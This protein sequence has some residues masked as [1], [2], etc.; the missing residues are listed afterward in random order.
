MTEKTATPAEKVDGPLL[1][2]AF[3]LVLGTFMASID[4]TIVSV[5]IDTLADEFHAS[6]AEIQWVSTAYLLAVV[7]AVP[8]SGW[9]AD[10]LGGRRVWLVAVGVFLCGS[11]LCALSW[12][13]TS[14]IV[15]RVLQGLGAG[16]LP[17]TGQALLARIAGPARTG[18]VISVVAVVPLLS[19]VLGPLAA[20]PC[21]GRPPGHGCSWS[22]CRSASPRS[23]SPAAMC[24]CWN[25]RP[26]GPR[27]MCGGP[28]C[29]HPASP[30]WCSA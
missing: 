20:A 6:L 15:F 13:V 27:S 25:R 22:T 30:S 24:R 28:Y 10:R 8:A 29:C 12:S 21:S 17:P 23:C 14:L 2:I 16:V 3:I 26:G 5:G 1:R 7:T 11:A 18:R 4:A 19:P 9:L